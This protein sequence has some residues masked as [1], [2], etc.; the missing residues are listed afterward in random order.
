MTRVTLERLAFKH[1]RWCNLVRNMGCNEAYIEDVVQD[2][3]IKIYSY[4]EN[5]LD[6]NYGSDDV[7]DFYFYMTLRSVYFGSKQKKDINN[8]FVE[9]TKDRLEYVFD[10]LKSEFYDS[11]EE[12]AFNTLINSIFTE[13]NSW[14]F[15]DKNVFIAY[16]STDNSIRTLANDLG[17]G[18]NSIFNTIKTFRSII[19]DKFG[20]DAQDYLNGDYN[21]LI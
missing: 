2:A 6:I 3:Y 4:L 8:N 13:I 14:S 21:K 11:E 18:V 15:Y 19:K 1:Q 7:N 17:V 5:G 16:F 12:E 10:N 9:V 20:E